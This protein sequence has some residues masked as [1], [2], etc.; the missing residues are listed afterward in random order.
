MSTDAIQ[1]RAIRK[2]DELPIGDMHVCRGA[3]IMVL[4]WFLTE[5]GHGAV[6]EAF[7]RTRRRLE[8]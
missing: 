5:I 3:A 2:L 8:F 1:A 6:A 7:A 4:L